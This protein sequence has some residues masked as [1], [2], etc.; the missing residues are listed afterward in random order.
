MKTWKEAPT[1]VLVLDLEK[2]NRNIERMAASARKN[3]VK[4]RPHI[5]THKSLEV[6]KRQ[7]HAGATGLTVAT[8]SEAEVFQNAGFDDL[9]VAFPLRSEEKIARFVALAKRGRL[10]A[11]I[12]DIVQAGRL[13]EAAATAGMRVEVWVKVNSGLNR[14]GV[15]P[16][17]E[18][19][20]LVKDIA[21]LQA[22]QV[23]GLYTHAGHAYGAG[24]QEDRERIAKEEAEAVVRS[25]EAC[26]NA[27]FPI[28]NRSVGSTPTYEWSGAYDGITEVRPGNAVFFDG[29]QEGLG[30]CTMDECALT[31]TASVVSGKKDRL[32]VDAGSKS[33]TLEKGAH[34]NASVT[35]F[36]T[37]VEPV[38]LAGKSLTRLSEEHGILDFPDGAPAITDEVIRIIP[39]HA[40]TAVNLYD[41]YLVVEGDTIADRWPV[42]AR[43]CNT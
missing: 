38:T 42:D 26:E 30:V 8:L 7:I 16:G 2:M 27:G 5:K 41:H 19:V 40:C 9:L 4:L 14:C 24:A 31:V 3:N 36:G 35:G 34:G 21:P 32:I 23:T 10:I 28:E 20:S 13:D 39:N 22:L 37:I 15:D 1:P 17:E 12:D 25:A 11:T 33:L 6:A 43:G 18:A 29:V